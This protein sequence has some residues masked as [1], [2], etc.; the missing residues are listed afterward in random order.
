M[1][2]G[3]WGRV[4]MYNDDNRNQPVTHSFSC[5]QPHYL[6]LNHSGL[7]LCLILALQYRRLP[8]DSTLVILLLGLKKSE[9]EQ[10]AGKVA[11]CHC[12]HFYSAFEVSTF[13][14]PVFRGNTIKWKW[15]E[16]FSATLILAS[17]SFPLPTFIREAF[18][19]LVLL[20]N[21]FF[22]KICMYNNYIVSKLMWSSLKIW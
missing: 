14:E 16:I 20:T 19:E 22:S 13:L 11:L 3:T 1:A 7:R 17:E 12:E 8:P 4:R 5:A 15:K 21:G 10:K 6:V 9:S 18:M 2:D